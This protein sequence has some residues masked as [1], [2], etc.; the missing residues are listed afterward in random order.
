VTGVPVV[1]T[2]VAGGIIRIAQAAGLLGARALLVGIRPDV[3]QAI[4]GPGLDLSSIT[5][6][7][8]LQS[9]IRATLPSGTTVPP[10][11]RSAPAR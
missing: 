1:D 5:T 3:A 10:T 6:Y 7:A 2:Q 4:V 8:S 11:G 9:G